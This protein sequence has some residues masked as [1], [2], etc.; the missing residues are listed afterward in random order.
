MNA[1]V[2]RASERH[3][4]TSQTTGMV[5]E[6]AF[7]SDTMWAGVAHNAPKA[8][9]GWHHHGDYESAIYVLNG[10]VRI[11]CGPGGRTVLDGGPG[12]FLLIPA[13]EVHREGNPTDGT[14][15]IVLVRAGQGEVVFN[16]DGPRD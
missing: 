14:T 1:K 6:E 11:E 7:K 8:F 9:S 16:V 4:Q 12:D 3:A 2:V 5:R 15:E 13:H 10:H